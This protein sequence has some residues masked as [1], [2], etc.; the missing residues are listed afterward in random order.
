MSFIRAG[1]HIRG[2][3]QPSTNFVELAIDADAAESNR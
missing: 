1:E 2:K 3:L